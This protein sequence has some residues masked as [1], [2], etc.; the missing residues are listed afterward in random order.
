MRI[1]TAIANS[2]IA[3]IKYWGNR[4][5]ELVLPLNNSLSFTM[6]DRLQTKTTVLFDEEFT[7]DELWINDE[8]AS[9]EERTRVSDFLEII[10]EK[11][12]IKLKSKVFSENSFPKGAGLASSASA[13]A[14]LAGASTKALG[15]NLSNKELSLFARFGSGS[16]S[17]SLFGGAVEWNKGEKQDGSDCY[18]EQIIPKE[19]LSNL[20]NIIAIVERK[21]KKIGSRKGM[22]ISVETSKLLPK[23][24]EGVEK[25][26]NIAKDAIINFN[27]QKLAPVIMEDSD[28]MH[29]VMQDSS[30][31]LVYLNP[32]SHRIINSIKELN[33]Q[34]KEY[35]GAYTFD[36]G[37]NAHIYTL[38]KNSKEIISVLKEIEGVQEIIECSMGDGIRFSESHLM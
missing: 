18:S 12:K 32:T 25:R 8:K 33:S 5:D 35:L 2:N 23:R 26:L 1:A 15:L 37:P 28:S 24:V 19:K 11:A 21:E 6:D 36:A 31:S 17:R 38:D 4:N 30:P 9:E 16:A 29:Q 3:I 10:R 7:E 20:R 14:A 13:F 22:K 34:N 27:F